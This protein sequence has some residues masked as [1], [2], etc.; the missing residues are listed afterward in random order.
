MDPLSITTS[1][2]TLLGAA[3]NV[4][5]ALQAI[6]HADRGLQSLVREVSTLNGYLRSIDKALEDCRGSAY[7]LSH[8]DP[9]LWKESKI[10]LSD[11]QETIDELGSLF[12]EPKRPSRSNTLFRKARVAAELRSRAGDIASF[13]EKISMSNLSL[14][15]LLQVINVSLSLRS[16]ESHDT[17]LR[18]LKE[19]KDALKKSSQAAT[20]S[21]STLFLNEQDIRLVHHLKGL[22]RA[23]H[24]FHTSASVTAS[25]VAGTQPPP[26]DFGDDD[27][28]SGFSPRLPSMKRQQIETYLSENQQLTR[29]NTSVSSVSSLENNEIIS[30]GPLKNDEVVLETREIDS[31]HTFS[32]IF[33]SG[34]SKIAQRALQQLDL[35]KAEGLLK[36]ALKWHS[37]SGSNDIHQ[38]RR[39]QTQLALCSLLQ[40]NRQEAQ[41]LI[42]DLVDSSADQDAIAHQLLY[43]LALLQLHELDFEEARENSKRLWAALQRIPHCT[44]LEANDA[45]R[46]LATS[47][48]QSG[49]GLLADAIEAELPGLRL[50]EPMPRMVDFLVDCEELLVGIFGLQ[51]YPEISRSLSVVRKIHNLPIAKNLSSL[52]IREQQLDS[53]LSSISECHSSDA[54]DELSVKA[55]LDFVNDQ[56]KAKKRS[57]SNLRALFRPRLTDLYPLNTGAQDSTF[58]LKSI[59]KVSHVAPPSPRATSPGRIPSVSS[60]QNSIKSKRNTLTKRNPKIQNTHDLTSTD[61]AVTTS[62]ATESQDIQDQK[63]QLQRQFSFQQGVADCLPEKPSTATLDPLYEMPNN[64]IFELMDTS[65]SVEPATLTYE[66]GRQRNKGKRKRLYKLS[67]LNVPDNDSSLSLCLSNGSTPSLDVD[68]PKGL[69]GQSSECRPGVATTITTPLDM[70]N[71]IYNLLGYDGPDRE[72]AG[73]N[74]TKLDRKSSSASSDLDN[75]DSSSGSDSGFFSDFDHVAPTTRQTTFDSLLTLFAGE[76]EDSDAGQGSPLSVTRTGTQQATDKLP[77]QIPAKAMGGY[78]Q[79]IEPEESLNPLRARTLSC[80]ISDDTAEPGNLKSNTRSR[81]E[82]G[83]AVARLCRYKSPQKTVFRSKLPVGAAA[84]LRKLFH[85]E[86]HGDGFDFG[87][88][89]ALYTGPDAVAGPFTDLSEEKQG[90]PEF[91][92][93]DLSL[94]SLP[95]LSLEKLLDTSMPVKLHSRPKESAD[96]ALV[97]K[98]REPSADTD[99]PPAYDSDDQLGN[100]KTSLTRTQI[101]DFFEVSQ[102]HAP[103]PVS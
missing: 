73:Q 24:D 80:E 67:K 28:R 5:N 4:Y 69:F 11:C 88:N 97:V 57:W 54:D 26:T 6:R 82:F 48:Q 2:I 99:K 103:F 71:D 46:V 93:S 75:L 87:F 31:D 51:D 61:T 8:I 85:S 101:D 16:N 27:A 62:T 96:E 100:R 83:L 36:E 77:S 70:E 63:N 78:G 58:K 52:Q 9:A 32:N 74:P 3:S 25:T 84:G 29:S 90:I 65:P 60:I 35:G 49:D 98:K 50:S 15:T 66:N 53:M 56:P 42:L 19:L 41:V 91:K 7:A 94:S 22:I 79:A 86:D 64:A 72:G 12:K 37:S 40:G 92:P 38:Q 10:A 34:F 89:K 45:M 55:D 81:R 1:V 76:D 13:R 23:A 20:V 47:Y 59:V 14:Q 43:A 33:T 44:V 21:Y 95:S 102:E 18:D 30:P 68:F 39:L 17:I